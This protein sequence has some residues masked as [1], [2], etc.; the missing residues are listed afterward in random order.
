MGGSDTYSY[1]NANP[2][3]LIDPLGLAAVGSQGKFDCFANCVR[4]ESFDAATAICT[5]VTGFGFGKMPKTSGEARGGFGPRDR[6]SPWTS[7]PS[8]WQRRGI[9]SGGRAFGQSIIG[10]ALGGVATGLLVGEGFYN[11]SA[12]GRCLFVCAADPSAY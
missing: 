2:L 11:I 5:L 7:Q 6:H 12:I 3:L 8:R 1:V 4:Q 10:G 9:W